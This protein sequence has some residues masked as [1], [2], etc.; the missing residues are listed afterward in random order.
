MARNYTEFAGSHKDG[1]MAM[2]IECIF[3]RP[4]T[5]RPI[6]VGGDIF[7]GKI[8]IEWIK[9]RGRVDAD[10]EW[11]KD[12][13]ETRPNG[14]WESAEQAKEG[15]FHLFNELLSAAEEFNLLAVPL[16]RL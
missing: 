11:R 6:A 5:V 10:K 16:K 13:V 7:S 8:I 15:V 3:V 1:T 9:G 2:E 14:Y 12:T 4:D